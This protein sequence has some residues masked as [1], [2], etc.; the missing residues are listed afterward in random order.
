[1]PGIKQL[2][3]INFGQEATPGTAVAATARYRGMGMLKDELEL[4]FPEETIGY[5]PGTDRSYI[6]RLGGT[7]QLSAPATFEEWP[8]VGNAGIGLVA[9]TTDTGSGYIW[10]HTPPVLT[11]I[12]STDLKTLTI[13][14]GDN[15]ENEEMEYS[16]VED[17]EMS[18]KA[19]EAW[20]LTSNWR[21][22]QVTVST[23]TPTTD[24]AVPNVT[25]MLFSKSKLYIDLIG[26]TVGTTLKS[27]TFLEGS[28]KFTT[29]LQ[30]VEA[31]DGQ[32][33]FSFVKGTQPELVISIT[34]EH[35]GTATA[36]K[37]FWRAQTA[38]L[39]QIL[40]Q[41]PALSSAGAYTYK[42]WKVSCAGKWESFDKLDE[43]NG[44]DVIKATF[45]ARYNSTAAM[46]ASFVC[47]NELSVMP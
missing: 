45:R 27:N 19:G 33:Y 20:M 34:F 4:T 39:L 18:G 42:T 23:V 32:L 6:A 5:L 2:R 15:Q 22:R 8:Y 17:F 40:I 37:V 11:A 29:G 41:G 21:G 3:V 25:D 13:E 9:P 7:I 16:F 1:M 36:E 10:T 28:I 35:D 30:I 38:R 44:N 24:V 14:G 26:G 31:A 12:A 43:I 47:V 46:F